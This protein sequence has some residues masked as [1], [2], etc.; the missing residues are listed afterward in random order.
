MI[1]EIDDK[2]PSYGSLKYK[3]E[4]IRE[5]LQK[6][7]GY[8]K[9]LIMKSDDFALSDMCMENA[10]VITKGHHETWIKPKNPQIVFDRLK[11][12]AVPYGFDFDNNEVHEKNKMNQICNKK[13]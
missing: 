9:D 13:Y 10:V 11:P 6:D 4:T 2:F 7:S 5:V 3:G 8:V 1:Y 12:Y